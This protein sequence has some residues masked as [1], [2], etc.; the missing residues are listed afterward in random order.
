LNLRQ[1][2]LGDQGIYQLAIALRSNL[3]ITHLLLQA[4][5]ITHHGIDFL[6][7]E[8]FLYGVQENDPE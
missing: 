4:N 1:V 6:V 2:S 3:N 5:E 8:G 7:N